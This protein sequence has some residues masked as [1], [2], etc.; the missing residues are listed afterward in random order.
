MDPRIAMALQI[1]QRAY[2]QRL[3]LSRLGRQ[4]GLS[5]SRFGYLFSRE[6]GS[7]FKREVQEMRLRQAKEFLADCT[8]SVKEVCFRVGYRWSP[9]FTRDFK[10]RFGMTPSQ[11]RREISQDSFD[12]Q[13]PI[14]NDNQSWLFPHLPFEGHKPNGSAW[15]GR[16]YKS[17]KF[18][19]E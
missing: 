1:L 11:F 3:T 16:S 13:P 12:P 8:L 9:N 6:T 4:V 5:G 7:T 17:I 14:F 15:R 2:P 10:M 18:R 19:I